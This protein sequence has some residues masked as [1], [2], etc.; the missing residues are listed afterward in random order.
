MGPT[1]QLPASSLLT[2]AV[3]PQFV[4]GS[5]DF[6]PCSLTFLPQQHFTWC[7]LSLLHLPIT[8]RHHCHPSTNPFIPLFSSSQE[9][10]RKSL[11]LLSWIFL[12]S[13][14][15]IPLHF[16]CVSVWGHKPLSPLSQ[17]EQQREPSPSWGSISPLGSFFPLFRGA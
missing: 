11:P 15:S 9:H 17:C 4:V 6:L 10:R 5:A 12:H 7:L 14:H 3:S 2:L 8:T 1:L 13:S 16:L